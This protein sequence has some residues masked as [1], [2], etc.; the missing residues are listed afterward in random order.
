MSRKA[1]I[2]STNLGIAAE[3]AIATGKVLEYGRVVL[4]SELSNRLGLSRALEIAFGHQDANLV[5]MSAVYEECTGGALCRLNEW[6]E[7]TW[8]AEQH[9]GASPSAVTRLCSRLGLCEE[10]YATF[11]REWFKSNGYPQSLISDTT[12]ISSYSEK[13]SILEW[14]HNRDRE[15]MPQLN[16]NMVHARET[17]LPLFYR[18]LYGSVPDIVTITT[19]AS[20]IS[21]LGLNNYSFALDRGFFSNENIWYFHDN[22]LGFTI[23]VPLNAHRSAR[24]LLENCRTKLHTFNSTICL[25]ETTLNH[26]SAAYV[27]TRKNRETHKIES[28]K[29][30]AHIYLNRIRQAEEERQFQ[31]LLN[32][33]MRDFHRT[34]FQEMAEVEQW[35]SSKI[36]K[37]K[38]HLF[39]WTGPAKPRGATPTRFVNSKDGGFRLSVR[40][41]EYA[42]AVRDMGIFMILNSDNDADGEKTLKDNRSRDLQEKVFDILKNTTGNDRIKVSNDDTLKGRLFLAFIAVILHKAVEKYLRSANMLKTTSVNKALDLARKFNVICL[43]D[44]KKIPLEVPKKSRVIYEIIVPGLLKQHGIDP[45][46]AVAIAQKAMMSQN[47]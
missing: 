2:K 17:E 28:F 36:G 33:I 8:F 11:F 1:L 13:L 12:S 42:R 32:G 21:G 37:S 10:E 26:M 25:G 3:Q 27:F 23:G 22:K 35:L 30:T 24:N 4:L 31:E 5:F 14:G 29:A 15:K 9:T 45:G 40:E 41:A 39:S 6:L 18:E 34:E 20:I 47:A 19:T 16:L 7:D 38:L 44:G 43:P 46:E